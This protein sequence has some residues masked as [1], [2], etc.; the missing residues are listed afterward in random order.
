MIY[1][2]YDSK[3]IPTKNHILVGMFY[4][5]YYSIQRKPISHTVLCSTTL[6]DVCLKS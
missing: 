3:N 2:F 4:K 5:E 6:K 1:E